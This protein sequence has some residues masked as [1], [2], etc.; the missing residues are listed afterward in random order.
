MIAEVVQNKC[1]IGQLL[2]QAGL[3]SE[4]QLNLALQNQTIP[5]YE[6]LNLC[7]LLA[8]RGWVNQET[9]DFFVIKW[10]QIIAAIKNSKQ[11]KQLS[12]YLVDAHLLTQ[13]QVEELQ[14]QQQQQKTSFGQLAVAKG[15]LKQQTLDFFAKHLSVKQN[16]QSQS[17]QRMNRG[18]KYFKL[19]DVKGA[20]LEIRSAVKL[21]PDNAPAHAWLTLIYLDLGQHSL[22]KVH[23]K[24][25]MA[26]DADH[27][28]VKEV[29]KKVFAS[30]P[31]SP[32][33]LAKKVKKSGNSGWLKI[34]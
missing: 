22:A 18:A 7:E 30:V 25:A 12:D 31:V 29:Q 6:T 20:I 16:K 26:L 1:P 11:C 27:V 2:Q 32:V 23:L 10:P 17:I 28:F 15:Y 13:A 8:L 14:Q 21:Q 33:Q 5:G 9:S 24:K 19:G 34:G 4:N 3:I